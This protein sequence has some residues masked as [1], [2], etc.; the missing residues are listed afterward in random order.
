MS[1]QPKK[2]ESETKTV[3]SDLMTLV[4]S[5]HK[6]VIEMR[7]ALVGDEDLGHRGLFK[8][9][10]TVERLVYI[11]ILVVVVFGGKQVLH[12]FLGL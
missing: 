11:L 5:I 4:Q 9:V 3:E 7:Q 10:A 8:R 12:L 2:Q 6:E 1:P